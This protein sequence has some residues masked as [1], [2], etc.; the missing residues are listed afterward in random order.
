M[1]REREKPVIHDV[2]YKNENL[3]LK[4]LQVSESDSEEGNKSTE[5]CYYNE[6]LLEQTN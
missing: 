3:L 6:N 4:K 2:D 1:S 5:S